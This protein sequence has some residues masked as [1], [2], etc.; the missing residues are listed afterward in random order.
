MLD[1][2]EF[3]ILRRSSDPEQIDRRHAR[4]DEGVLVV[5]TGVHLLK[6][7]RAIGFIVEG[8]FVKNQSLYRHKYLENSRLQR[9]PQLF[10]SPE[11]GVEQTQ[12]DLAVFIKIRV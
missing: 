4:F 8:L 3:E 5:K 2:E 9:I 1:G 10:L 6:E 12:A 11:P 7:T